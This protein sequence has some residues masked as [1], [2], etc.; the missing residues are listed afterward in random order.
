MKYFVFLLFL[1]ISNLNAYFREIENIAKNKPV[2]Q[3]T[4]FNDNH[5][6]YF[7]TNFDSI[8][9]TTMDT[10]NDDGWLIVDLGNYYQITKVCLWNNQNSG[11][12]KN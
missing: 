8:N 11:K 6:A 4:T 10:E 1:F 3:K 9:A 5:L 2:Y 7:A 12:R